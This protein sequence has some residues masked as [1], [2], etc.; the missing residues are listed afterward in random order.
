MRQSIFLGPPGTV[1]RGL[2]GPTYATEPMHLEE[3]AV[4]TKA[5]GAAN[6]SLRAARF[7]HLLRLAQREV[8]TVET[9]R[10]HETLFRLPNAPELSRGAG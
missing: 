1:A 5:G 4:A 7:A 6:R 3:A 10:N 9:T 2:L 8:S